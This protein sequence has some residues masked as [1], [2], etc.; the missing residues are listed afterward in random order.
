[1]AGPN[2]LVL[3]LVGTLASFG[4]I[5]AWALPAI[6]AGAVLLAVL[7]GRGPHHRVPRSGT[8]ALD[9]AIL[10][11]VIAIA[12]QAVPLPRWLRATLSPHAAAVEARL[13]PDAAVRDETFAALS[14]DPAGTIDALL[15]VVAVALT[16]RAARTIFARGG[17]R[18]VSRAIAITG[19]IFAVVAII[20]RAMTPGL[21][22]GVWEPT[23]PGAQPFGPVVNRNHFAGWLVMASAVIA[24]DLMARL[25]TTRSVG[26]PRRRLTRTIV[27]A[28][29]TGTVWMAAAWLVTTLTVF[30]AQSRSAVLALVAML[31]AFAHVSRSSWRAIAS[32]LAAAAAVGV[33]LV[34]AG[35]PI[36]MQMATRF[37]GTFERGDVGRLV[38]W[39]ETLPIVEDFWVTGVGAGAYGRAMLT[40]Q[41]TR[42]YA[43]HLQSDRHFNHAHNHYLQVLSEG[44]LLVSVPLLIVFAL[45]LRLTVRRLGD[46]GTDMRPRRIGA[47]AGLTAMAAQSIWEV[48][49]TMPAAA[50]LAATLAGLATHE[51]TAL[52]RAGNRD[53]PLPDPPHGTLQVP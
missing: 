33:A 47:V 46:D 35:Q 38:I 20:Q 8:R 9:R 23:D 1:M 25:R 28:A 50:L 31:A 21:I 37:A 13:R 22:Y 19:A 10:A 6:A 26:G 32:A 53:T 15:L 45:F 4:G 12:L 5:Y 2:V 41:Q 44:G 29:Q 51:R 36:A 14:L 43:P 7:A 39:R 27:H 40:Y 52:P 3:L 18:K 49:L 11:L 17:V 42:A 30:I 24:G 34:F 48:P 16:Y